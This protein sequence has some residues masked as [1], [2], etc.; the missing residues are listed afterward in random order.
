MRILSGI[1]LVYTLLAGVVYA[2]GPADGEAGA[3]PNSA[4]NLL[5]SKNY[6][7]FL[8]ETPFALVEY[9]AP[10]CGYCKMLGPEFSKASEILKESHPNIK[11]G[12]INCEEETDICKEEEIRGFP[13]MKVFKGKDSSVQYTGPRS[14]EGIAEYMVKESLPAVFISQTKDE[15]NE[16]IESQTQPFMVQVLPGGYSDNK[17]KSKANQTFTELAEANRKSL[18][19]VTVNNEEL[20]NILKK[21]FLGV[22]FE[23]KNP[24]YFI[25]QPKDYKEAVKFSKEISKDNLQDFINVEIVPYFGDINKDTYMIYMTSELPLAYYFY[26]D[27]NQKKA[28]EG[29]IVKAA[30]KYRY[31]INF[32]GLDANLYGRHAEVLNMDPEVVPLFVINSHTTNKK[33]GISQ[34]DYP[35]GPPAKVILKFVDDFFASKL[36]PIIKSEELPSQEEVT[37]SPVYPLV[38][39]NHD[40]VLGDVSKDIMIEYYASW[41]GFCKRLAPVWEELGALYNGSDAREQVVIAKIDHNANDVDTSIPV[42]AYPTILFYPAYG[43]M[44]KATGLRKAIAFSGG[45]DLDSFVNFIKENGYHKVDGNQL[46]RTLPEG[47]E[48]GKEEASASSGNR[49]EL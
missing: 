38:A 47:E 6:Q 11:L 19:F 49:D 44:D 48:A 34:K 23:S 28:V 40:Q 15:L 3:D 2:G 4:V 17:D 1:S 18:T 36:K 26:T 8:D 41:C 22:K 31:K 14:A 45:R 13:T 33:Y 10:W 39:H 9:Y 32:V 24:T 37:S 42:E 12:Q 7:K 46:K 35:K 25:S 43:E 21:K 30:K 29:A 16:V 27:E 20:A 5:T